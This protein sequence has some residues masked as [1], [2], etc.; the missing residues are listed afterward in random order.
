MSNHHRP[1]PRDDL[2]EIWRVCW[3]QHED[4]YSL[5]NAPQSLDGWWV[6]FPDSFTTG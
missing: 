1:K 6:F 5:D 3:P 4:V 2:L